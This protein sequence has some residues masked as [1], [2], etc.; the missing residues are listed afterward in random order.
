[1]CSH[2]T[3]GKYT[4][5]KKKPIIIAIGTEEKKKEIFKNLYKL[6]RSADN[7]TIT[8]DL[9]VQQREKLHEVIKEAKNKEECDQSGKV[10]LQ[11]LWSTMGMVCEE[12]CKIF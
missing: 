3:T 7:I 8:H 11:S 12:N 4:E 2:G 1:M 6:R 5:G 10:Y 9:I